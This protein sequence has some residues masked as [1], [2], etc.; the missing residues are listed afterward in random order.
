M[1]LGMDDKRTD[2]GETRPTHG[3]EARRERSTKV[4]RRGMAARAEKAQA[5]KGRRRLPKK[6]T[7]RSGEGKKAAGGARKEERV[8]PGG[9]RTHFGKRGFIAKGP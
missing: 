2:K 3:P 4:A 6:A 5:E 8:T 7:G 9:L 1:G